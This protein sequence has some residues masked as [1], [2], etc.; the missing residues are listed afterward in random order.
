MAHG[1]D[2]DLAADLTCDLVGYPGSLLAEET[3]EE[4]WVSAR[5]ISYLALA[6]TSHIQSTS[7]AHLRPRMTNPQ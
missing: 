5:L 7:A 2:Y 6:A 4:T 3:A 1:R